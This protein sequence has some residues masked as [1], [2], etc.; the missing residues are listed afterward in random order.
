MISFSKGY[1]V[2]SCKIN[3]NML[4]TWINK[5]GESVARSAKKIEF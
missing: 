1:F 4:E 3:D 5:N 2:R